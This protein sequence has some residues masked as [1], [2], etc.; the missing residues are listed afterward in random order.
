MAVVAIQVM[1]PEGDGLAEDQSLEQLRG[2]FGPG[3]SGLAA[4]TGPCAGHPGRGRSGQTTAAGAQRG[5]PRWSLAQA[6]H[7]LV[8]L[9]VDAQ[10]QQDDAVAEIDA[11]D[12]HRL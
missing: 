6:Q 4:S 5:W 12:H 11:V 7:V 8:S 9:G 2:L 10:R 3:L 1:A